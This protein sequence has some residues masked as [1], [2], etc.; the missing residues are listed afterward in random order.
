MAYI[1]CR[2]RYKAL[3]SKLKNVES[4]MTLVR[5]DQWRN[6]KFWAPLQTFCQ[7]PLSLAVKIL[8][9]A[10][11]NKRKCIRGSTIAATVWLVPPVQCIHADRT[12][13]RSANAHV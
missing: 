4:V 12:H 10:L 13:G 3:N 1:D 5:S 6:Y 8:F 11:E 2:V 7:G 9:A